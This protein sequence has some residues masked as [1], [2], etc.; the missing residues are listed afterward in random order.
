MCLAVPMKLIEMTGEGTG[1]VDSGGVKA[2][3]S[4]TMVPHAKIGDYL[5][6]HA[7]FG[8]EVLDRQEADVRLE[9]FRELAQATTG[10][11]EP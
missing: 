8:I 4:L 7:G 6:V 9:L 10:L 2:D 11:E 5:I 1:K 3:V